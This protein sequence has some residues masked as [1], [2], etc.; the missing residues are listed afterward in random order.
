MQVVAVQVFDPAEQ[1][2]AQL[3]KAAHADQQVVEDA[4]EFAGR[5]RL[6]D[7]A[8]QVRQRDEQGACLD[9]QAEILRVE[10]KRAAGGVGPDAE[11]DLL[12]RVVQRLLRD[13]HQQ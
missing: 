3:V 13:Q 7:L 5:R 1:A 2:G 10:L 6:S 12:Q 8:E 11:A 4:L 9:P